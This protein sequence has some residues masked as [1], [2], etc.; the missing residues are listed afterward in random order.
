V[1]RF[2]THDDDERFYAEVVSRF[3]APSVVPSSEDVSDRSDA[4]DAPRGALRTEGE[5]VRAFQAL[6]FDAFYGGD[7]DEEWVEQ[8]RAK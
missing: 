5:C 1:H 2:T 7:A 3:C 4:S 6:G 8:V